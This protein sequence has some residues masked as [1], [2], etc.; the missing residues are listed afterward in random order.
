[1]RFLVLSSIV[2]LATAKILSSSKL[3]EISRQ[4]RDDDDRL[5]R[6]NP[7]DATTKAQT[8]LC[9]FMISSLVE[10]VSSS[11]PLSVRGDAA[12]VLHLCTSQNTA[13]RMDIGL[14]ENGEIF[15]GLKHLIR[16]G[17]E[18]MESINMMGRND[19]NKIIVT[20]TAAGNAIAKASEA[21]WIL[22]YNNESNQKGFFE[23]G[24]VEELIQTIKNCPVFFDRDGFC[25]AANMWSL[26]ALQNL[27]ASYCD[28]ENGYCD[29]QRNDQTRVLTLPSGVKRITSIDKDIRAIIMDQIKDKDEQSFGK[30]LNYMVCSGPVNSP[31]D[32]TYSW[33]GKAKYPHSIPHPE[34][35]PWAAIGLIKNLAIDESTRRYFS[36][37]TQDNGQ[38]FMCLCDIL[39]NTPDWLEEN[40]ATVATYRMGWDDY[41]P[42]IHDRCSD[43]EGWAES[44][45]GK[46]CS[47][48][49]SERLCASMGMKL[50]RGIPANEAC[51]VCGGG[52]RSD[53]KGQLTTGAMRDFQRIMESSPG[54]S[55]KRNTG[56]C[57]R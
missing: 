40:K 55:N 3:Q 37:K 20:G 38:L 30:L 50:G 54:S 22:S 52:T 23:A 2:S 31:H 57:G 18:Q 11:Q 10:T 51:C 8:E 29:W 48:Y 47:D 45:T 26:A 44:E 9:P 27:A 41:C 28:S 19:M 34:I 1:M 32:D 43:K 6:P 17:M 53:S 13:N 24:V 36:E 12:E 4:L 14:A 7:S 16:S 33:P 56:N 15:Q 49:E 42:D 25:S 5:I 35:V 46:T 21:I 39:K